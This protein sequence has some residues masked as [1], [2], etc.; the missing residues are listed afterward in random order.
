MLTNT[1]KKFS[2]IFLI[3]VLLELITGS[4]DS[5]NNLH[6]IAKPAIVISLLILFLRTNQSLSKRVKN[7]T[8]LALI[9]ALLGDVLLMFVDKSEHFFTLGLVAFLVAHIMYSVL[10]LKHK[11]KKRKAL[12][13]IILLLLY[14]SGLFYFLKDGLGDMLIPV[15]I[16]MIVILSMATTAYLRKSNVTTL[17]YTLVFLGA[18]SFMLSDSILALNKFYQTLPWSNISIMTTYAL[19]QYLIVLGILKLKER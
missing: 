1:E 9:F 13:F 6:Y 7:Y 2:V 8:I 14:A 5:L 19:A 3:I 16:Y 15:V 17:S 12:G 18:L 4:Y 10:F 11:H